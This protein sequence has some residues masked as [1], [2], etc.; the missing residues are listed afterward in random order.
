MNLK[1]ILA[2]ANIQK[3]VGKSSLALQ[4]AQFLSTE[5]GLK[6]LLI[7]LDPNGQRIGAMCTSDSSDP[8]GPYTA[9]ALF[10]KK[11][12]MPYHTDIDNLDVLPGEPA[13]A[14]LNNP[15]GRHRKNFLAM[16]GDGALW[17]AYSVVILDTPCSKG[18][19]VESALAASTYTLIPCQRHL[20]AFEGVL[21]TL[22]MCEQQCGPLADPEA[23]ERIGVLPYLEEGRVDADYDAA[24]DSSILTPLMLESLDSV[25]PQI[26]AR[27]AGGD[28]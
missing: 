12:W 19:L 21:V 22:Q 1:R 11:Q 3:G 26:W 7:D 24:C 14:E 10:D 6:T 20:R 25:G 23:S 15:R 5:R 27:M 2:V 9:K 8:K 13:L 28:V 18:F 17:D 4:L 16:L